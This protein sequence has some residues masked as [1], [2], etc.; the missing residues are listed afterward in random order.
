MGMDRH[1]W[2]QRTRIL[3]FCSGLDL[4]LRM[5]VSVLSSHQVSNVPIGEDSPQPQDNYTEIQ[6]LPGKP[7]F[8]IH[9]SWDSLWASIFQNKQQKCKWK[10]QRLAFLLIPDTVFFFLN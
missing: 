1:S 4:C 8:S 2:N 5:T 7:A 3:I 6:D 10:D 9:P